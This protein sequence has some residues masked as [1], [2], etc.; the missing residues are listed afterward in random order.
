MKFGKDTL[1]HFQ[2]RNKVKV[3]EKFK[4]SNLEKFSHL[5]N[6]DGMEKISN[7]NINLFSSQKLEYALTPRL[8]SHSPNVKWHK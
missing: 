5:K 2:L 8:L 3:S 1:S 7:L 6:S 4:F